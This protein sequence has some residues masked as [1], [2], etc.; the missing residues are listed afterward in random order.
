V[1]YIR[2][3]HASDGD[4]P[5]RGGLQ[6]AD[7]KTL[8][9][10]QEAAS[11]CA[12]ALRFTLPMLIDDIDDKAAKAYGAYPD[13]LYIVAADGTVAYRGGPG[14]RGFRPDEMEEALRKLLAAGRPPRRVRL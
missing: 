13:R 7:P 5:L 11:Q 9:E 10:R 4:Q 1:V 14:P 3:A 12:G 8:L 6:L 2:E